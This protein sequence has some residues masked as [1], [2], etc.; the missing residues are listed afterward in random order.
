MT[1]VLGGRGGQSCHAT[2]SSLV[3]EPRSLYPGASHQTMNEHQTVEEA[4]QGNF[5]ASSMFQA[6]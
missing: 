3:P 4:L 5:Q 2:A 1:Q 6:E